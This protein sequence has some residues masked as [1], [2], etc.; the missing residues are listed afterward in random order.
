MKE[1]KLKQKKEKKISIKKISSLF[2]DKK[3]RYLYMI[4]FMLPFIIA[5]G[6]FG[7]IAY[8]E[9][10]SL[11]ELA[12]DEVETK[13]THKIESMNYVLRDNA[14][15][16]QEEYFTELKA[17]VESETQDPVTI[18]GLVGKNY[19]ADF[20]TWTN[21]QG[22]YDVGGLYYVCN[23]RNGSVKYKENIYQKARDGFYKYINEYINEYGVENLIEVASVEVVSSKKI[24]EGYD[25]YEYSETLEDEN[26]ESYHVYAYKNHDAYLV[27]LKWTYKENSKFDTSSY[28]NSINLIVIENGG[29]YEIVEASEEAINT[30]D[31]VEI[32]EETETE[33]SESE[34]D[35][36]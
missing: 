13:D 21:K 11:I 25:L 6:I 20:Y 16:V 24:D 26:G 9:A 23:G 30:K 28:A 2:E 34:S 8:K 5:I 3:K 4:L 17:A 31:Y 7:F 29:R 14:T 27:S 18:A 32:E 19:V 33:E 1:I 10:K 12:T 36:E 35:S 15:E 22:Q